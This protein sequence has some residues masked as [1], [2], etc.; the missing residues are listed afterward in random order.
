MGLE[1]VFTLNDV[2]RHERSGVVIT[3]QL[4]G[5]QISLYLKQE[6]KINIYIYLGFHCSFSSASN[7]IENCL[8]VYACHG[9]HSKLIP[10]FQTCFV[11]H[12]LS[13]MIQKIWN[14]SIDY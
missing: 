14:I 7:E 2:G 10:G 9:T 12:M 5:S 4:T 8:Q 11:N 1:F 13:G 6:I 3:V